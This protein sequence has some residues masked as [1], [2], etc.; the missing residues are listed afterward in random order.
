MKG[1][2][3]GLALLTLV[4][5]A[6]AWKVSQDKA[7]QT[8][9][10]RS[11][12]Y[13]GLLDRLNEVSRVRLSSG[14]DTTLLERD[15]ERW[16][17]A[18]KDGYPADG[19]AVRRAVLQL[20]SLR[21]VEPKTAKAERYARL[22][23]ED[24]GDDN[25]SGTLVELLAGDDQALARLIVGNSSDTTSDPRYYVRRAGE[26]QS[27]LVEGALTVPADPIP[28]VDAS[29]VD[30]D[31]ARVAAVR[32]E[33]AEGAPVVI[34]KAE[35]DDSFFALE[36]VP[37][38]HVAKSKAPISSCGAVLLDLRF[39]DVMSADS[40][41]GQAPLRTVTVQTF[42]GLTVTMTDY[43]HNDAVVTA[44]TFAASETT[45]TT[46]TEAETAAAPANAV[47]ETGSVDEATETD[48]DDAS[49]TDDG[50]DAE[51]VAEE[52]MRLSATTAGWVYTLPD[53]KRRMIERDL[54]SLIEP[55]SSA[56]ADEAS[57]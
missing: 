43:A 32:I 28:W 40:V 2:T 11:Q 1:R 37:E 9:V 18:N 39:N 6:I 42:D 44:F 17:L 22:G 24:V 51:T 50:A 31:T 10:S 7:P 47:A 25:G 33:P 54:D 16:V 27:W 36:N 35:R 38:G 57:E 53:Y 13:P 30:V 21:V 56:Q 29:I 23:V 49:A 12:L 52:A 46:A 14:E 3:L 15:G 8:E 55:A 26:A 19:A 5:I 34:R 48:A 41:A 4:V 45:A 20:A